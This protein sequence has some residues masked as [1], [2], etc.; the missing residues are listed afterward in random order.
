M[1][2]LA[3]HA[4]RDVESGALRGMPDAQVRVVAPDAGRRTN[5]AVAIAN[6]PRRISSDLGGAPL[7]VALSSAGVSAS[8]TL[9]IREGT[10]ILERV[11]PIEIPAD[12]VHP[13]TVALPRRPSDAHSLTAALEP[14]DRLALDQAAFVAWHSGPRPAAWFVRPSEV[15][16]Q[17]ATAELI[18]RNLL[19]PEAL[20]E[21]ER[22]LAV[23]VFDGQA[24][25]P[26]PE[27]G[28]VATDLI[29][30]MPGVDLNDPARRAIVSAV[31]GGAVLLLACGGGDTT[32]DWPGLRRM[33][34]SA[35]PV[36][37]RMAATQSLA[38]TPHAD[39][40]ATLEPGVE[41]LTR[42][43]VRRRLTIEPAA[44]GVIEA[45]FS[46]GKAA[47]VSR[48]VGKGVAILLATSP[49]P[50]WSDLGLRA[51]GLLSWLNA[52][53]VRNRPESDRAAN[54]TL[55]ER[56]LRPFSALPDRGFVIVR[57][58]GAAEGRRVAIEA[59]RPVDGWP[60]RA[61]G[62]YEVVADNGQVLARYA[63]NWPPEES[64]LR[65]IT[66]ERAA[67]ILGVQAV[68]FETPEGAAAAG[69]D[70]A[71]ALFMR[72]ADPHVLLA[73]GLIALV[74]GEALLSAR[75]AA[76]PASGDAACEAG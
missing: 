16:P 51:A 33:L 43:P 17:D 37:E 46:D 60:A 74:A 24:P 62:L 4:W 59:G 19:A 48:R 72:M 14:A 45:R 1:T 38:W 66:A 57:P 41:E 69:P 15:A 6:P 29:V 31:E 35:P 61:A 75:R 49:D 53:A 76:R 18:W 2:D 44:G 42:T 10:R 73:I 55:G 3:A 50:A 25:L 70:A 12:A 26:R 34:G 52:L 8:A 27:Q 5:L 63:V 64:D 58:E 23:R 54:F 36:L 65:P 68:T 40:T 32:P 9:V 28:G 71:G 56:S 39:P 21:P 22:P 11:G 13:V 7:T 67:G 30:V 47:V 20:A